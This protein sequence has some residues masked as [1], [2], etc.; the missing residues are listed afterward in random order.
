MSEFLLVRVEAIRVLLRK[1]AQNFQRKNLFIVVPEL[2]TNTL[3]SLLLA[4]LRA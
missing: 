2:S 1:H 4:L 3:I